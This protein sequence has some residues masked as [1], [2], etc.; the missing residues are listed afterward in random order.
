M[1]TPMTNG[2]L[3]RLLLACHGRLSSRPGVK[4]CVYVSTKFPFLPVPCLVLALRPE[5]ST[6]CSCS[7]PSCPLLELQ[8][9]LFGSCS[10][11]ARQECSWPPSLRL[12]RVS[13]QELAVLPL[14]RLGAAVTQ[15]F[16]PGERCAWPLTANRAP[17]QNFPGKAAVGRLAA[18]NSLH[19]SVSSCF[20]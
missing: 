10:F 3:G 15:A 4:L 6:Y 14:A 18:A 13:A 9:V 8:T 19:S 17:R 7:H 11:R 20:F 5:T 2:I 1:S 16:G 12:P